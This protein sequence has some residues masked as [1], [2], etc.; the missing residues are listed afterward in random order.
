M[1]SGV[2]APGAEEALVGSQVEPVGIFGCD[3]SHPQAGHWRVRETQEQ[4]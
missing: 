3:H 4:K 2:G 1:P